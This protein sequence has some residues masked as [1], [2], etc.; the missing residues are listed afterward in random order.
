MDEE[1]GNKEFIHNFGRGNFWNNS[2]R[3]IEHEIEVIIDTDR[4]GIVC[5]AGSRSDSAHY[6]VKSRNLARLSDGF[7]TSGSIASA[8]VSAR[9]I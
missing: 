9:K 6:G 2:S 5:D 4:W 7:E 1:E 3:Q 8:L